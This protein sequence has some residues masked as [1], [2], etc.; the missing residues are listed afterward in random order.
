MAHRPTSAIV[1]V[2]GE[3]SR[4]RSPLPKPLHRLCGRPMV[5]HMLDALAELPIERV[6]IVVGH[7]ASEVQRVVS[8]ESPTHLKIEFVEQVAQLGTGDA[9]AVG[10]T[11]FPPS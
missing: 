3:G 9:T 2:A 6:V 10:L 1:L 7:G 4:M 11:G 5:I 8:A